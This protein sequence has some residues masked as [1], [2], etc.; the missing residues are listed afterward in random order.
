MRLS[1]VGICPPGQFE[2]AF[3]SRDGLGETPALWMLTL[4]HNAVTRR[5]LPLGEVEV[6]SIIRWTRALMTA[7]QV[8]RSVRIGLGEVGVDRQARGLR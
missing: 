2:L 6:G 5:K 8:M 3:R 7:T 4:F 1:E